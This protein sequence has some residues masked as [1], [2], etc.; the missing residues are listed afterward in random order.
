[1]KNLAEITAILSHYPWSKEAVSQGFKPLL[2][3]MEIDAPQRAALLVEDMETIGCDWPIKSEFVAENTVLSHYEIPNSDFGK[4][5]D[6][7]VQQAY[8]AHGSGLNWGSVIRLSKACEIGRRYFGSE[9][10][11]KFKGPL[12]DPK[13]HLPFIEELLWLN[14]WH[15]VSEIEREAS[16]FQAIGSKK[17]IDWR[18]KASGQTINLEVK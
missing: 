7:D 12:M 18:F 13:D 5:D 11:A 2:T 3:E 8:T 17:R 6:I 15:G 1:M 14:V 16:P 10:P 4:I 9:W